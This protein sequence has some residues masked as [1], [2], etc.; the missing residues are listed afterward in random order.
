MIN[1]NVKYDF[2]ECPGLRYSSQSENSGEEFYN[3]VLQ[4]AFINAIENKKKLYVNLDGV[5]GYASC[6]LDEAFGRLVYDFTLDVVKKT[7]TIISVEEPHWINMIETKTY[8]EWDT[9]RKNRIEA[10]IPVFE[11]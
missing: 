3:K 2:Y 9:K 1:V 8:I 11:E 4:P 6:F 5:D 10:G 7:L